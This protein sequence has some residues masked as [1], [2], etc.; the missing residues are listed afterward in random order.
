MTKVLF[1]NSEWTVYEDRMVHHAGYNYDIYGNYAE[2]RGDGPLWDW[3]L[4]IG[5]KNW[6][7]PNEF[8][9]AFAAALNHHGIKLDA[10]L[11]LS[12]YKLGQE[13]VEERVFK[14]AQKDLGYDPEKGI[15]LFKDY[16]QIDKETK[17][18]LGK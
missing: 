12:F 2:K 5:E 7:K 16:P 1:K 6:F 17:R 18:R 9:E 13:E 14:Q 8:A 10:G 11:M 4:Q 15:D 3:V